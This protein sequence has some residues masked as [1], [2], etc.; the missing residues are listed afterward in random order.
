MQDTAALLVAAGLSRR[1]GCFKP[2]MDL[3]G[4]PLIDHAL[5]TFRKAGVGNIVVV[6][7]YKAGEL[8]GHLAGQGISFVRN[9]RYADTAMFDSIKIGL[10]AL[11]GKCGSFFAM[12]ADIPLVQ[13]ETAKAM[14]HSMQEEPAGILQ[15]AFEG[16][17]GHPLLIEAA[18]IPEILAY[19]G[20]DGL[21]GFSD[22]KAHMK[23]VIP[24]D[25]PGIALDADTPEGYDEIKDVWEK[26]RHTPLPS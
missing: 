1:M 24:I 10:Q 19:K 14:M 17:C 4:K 22:S 6:T 12:P 7:G 16:K 8:E 21:K 9:E 25:D 3:G 23:R 18:C 5:D 26:T 13:P 20:P 2:L 15:P 11:Q